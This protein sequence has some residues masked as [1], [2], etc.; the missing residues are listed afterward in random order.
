MYLNNEI[1]MNGIS[2]KSESPLKS[3]QSNSEIIEK[4][5]TFQPGLHPDYYV[6]VLTSAFQRAVKNNN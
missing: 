1:I 3:S 4:L 6:P 5:F 2:D